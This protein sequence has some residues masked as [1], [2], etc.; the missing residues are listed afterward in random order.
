[1]TYEIEWEITG[2]KLGWLG[3]KQ[4]QSLASGKQTVTVHSPAIGSIMA[5]KAAQAILNEQWARNT[6]WRKIATGTKYQIREVA[7]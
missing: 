6:T 5:E 7:L 3:W 1:M 2:H 4:E